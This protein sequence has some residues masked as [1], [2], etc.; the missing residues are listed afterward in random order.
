MKRRVLWE[1]RARMVKAQTSHVKSTTWRP[2]SGY[3]TAIAKVLSYSKSGELYALKTDL[4]N[5]GIETTRDILGTLEN[6]K[7]LKLL[8]TDISA[9][10]CHEAKTRLGQTA[11]VN[12]DI[13]NI[14]FRDG[15]LD[16][17]FDLSTIDHVPL[18][19]VEEVLSEY[20]RILKKTALLLLFFWY[21]GSLL[22]LARR[23]RPPS[24]FQLPPYRYYFPIRSVRMFLQARGFD[25]LDEY[26]T[27]GMGK[28][29]LTNAA[30]T[31][32]R[33]ARLIYSVVLLLEYSVF[34]RLILKPFCGLVAI[35][36]KKS[37]KTK[38]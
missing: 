35:I 31:S 36:A 3:I 4:W 26:C 34:S 25:V 11:I 38:F 5:E 32:G 13:R 18:N 17:I 1:T 22:K 14:P 8:G 9:F 16:I 33:L 6:I 23:F 29:T 30:R 19:Q 20:Q 10:T 15:T 7:N 28:G 12:A 24:M 21:E 2:E 27:F 37:G